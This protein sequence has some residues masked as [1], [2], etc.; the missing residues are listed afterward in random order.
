[1]GLFRPG[2]VA[3][4]NEFEGKNGPN[5]GKK[6]ENDD[7]NDNGIGHSANWPV[8]YVSTNHN[9]NMTQIVMP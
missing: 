7:G 2:K 4:Q 1:M 9:N 6:C 8:I 5:E 3:K